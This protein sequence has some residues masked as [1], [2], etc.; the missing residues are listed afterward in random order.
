MNPYLLLVHWTNAP[1]SVPLW[2]LLQLTCCRRPRQGLL[3][4]LLMAAH[5]PCLLGCSSCSAHSMQGGGK[6]H[7]SAQVWDEVI[8]LEGV[9]EDG[10]GLTPRPAI[11]DCLSGDNNPVPGLL[12]GGHMQ[13]LLRVGEE[14]MGNNMFPKVVSQRESPGCPWWDGA[15]TRALYAPEPAL[16]PSHLPLLCSA[17]AGGASR[18]AVA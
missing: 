12:S 1:S 6:N 10:F 15:N 14:Q 3:P 7:H 16:Q 17:T 4:E 18:F 5:P 2:D 9:R 11:P 13:K 8:G